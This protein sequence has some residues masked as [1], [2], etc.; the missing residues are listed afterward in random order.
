M[1]RTKLAFTSDSRRRAGEAAANA[2]DIQNIY[3]ADYDGANQR[4]ITV[5]S[6]SISRPPGHRTRSRWRT[7]QYRSGFPDILVAEIYRPDSRPAKPA[8]A[9]E[10]QNFLAGLVA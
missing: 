1:A 5:A 3:I 8:N 4:R 6:R 10:K 9:P 2:R 7:R